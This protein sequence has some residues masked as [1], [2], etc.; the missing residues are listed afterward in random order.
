MRDADALTGVY[1]Y[2][3]TVAVPM[4]F[5][6]LLRSKIV[7]SV[8]AFDKLIHD[9]IRVGMVEIFM[10]KRQSTPKYLA[11]PIPLRV[12]QQLRI[13]STPPPELLFE[14]TVRA[15]LKALSFQDPDKVSDGLSYIWNE[16][17]KWQ[18]IATIIGRDEKIARTT[19]KLITARR[20]SIV[21]EADMDPTTHSKLPITRA[22]SNGVAS[23]LLDVGN[24]VCQLVK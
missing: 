16:D 12:A 9:L 18:R 6:D 13:T 5:D 1:D 14:Q 22:E 19:L 7:Y 21:H 20:N 15:K 2:L 11:E 24:A 10:G 4:S 8:S 17:Y 23:F 3:M